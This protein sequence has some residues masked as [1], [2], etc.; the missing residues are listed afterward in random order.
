VIASEH[1]RAE[2]KARMKA[3]LQ[4]IQAP[5]VVEDHQQ[6]VARFIEQLKATQAVDYYTVTKHSPIT[7]SYQDGVA[8]TS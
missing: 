3:L 7:F 5:M 2:K 6:Q 8:S 4:N 1:H